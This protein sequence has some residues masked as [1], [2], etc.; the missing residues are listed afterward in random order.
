MR[1]SVGDVRI[2]GGH[3][4]QGQVERIN[5]EGVPRGILS[6]HK[7]RYEFAKKYS[8]G[9]SVL[10][11]ACGAG[12]GSAMLAEVAAY[13]IGADLDEGALNYAR[14][15]YQ[16]DNLAYRIEDT[17]ALSFEDATF[18]A[19]VSFE[20]VEHLSDI[21]RYL[22]EV[23]RVLKPGGSFIVSTPKVRKTTK[24]PKNP[25]HAVE[26]SEEDFRALLEQYF[27]AVEMY[28]QM[29]IQGNLHYWLQKLDF[30][31]LRH[32]VPVRLRYRIDQRLGTSPFEE[33]EPSD[34]RIV[35]GDLRRAHN[36]IAL[37]LR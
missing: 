13:V 20:T 19:V 26:F 21:S 15:S 2:K 28:G 30:L 37:C 14:C 11:V 10:D 36:M 8:A 23:H 27:P 33:M 18:D 1:N 5:P 4:A 12:Y 6:L 34:Q 24:R 9:K 31:H 7:V 17:Q 35:K 29:R 16:R 22:E 3:K 25:H 32:F